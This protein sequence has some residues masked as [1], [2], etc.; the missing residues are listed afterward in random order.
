MYSSN[1]LNNWKYCFW[2][3]DSNFD[4]GWYIWARTVS[5]NNG[6]D[7]RRRTEKPC[8][9]WVIATIGQWFQGEIGFS[10]NFGLWVGWKWCSVTVL[11]AFQEWKLY[12]PKWGR[13]KSQTKRIKLSQLQPG[14]GVHIDIYP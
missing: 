11:V 1:I 4:D 13:I 2:L 7:Y 5:L 10:L 14:I 6:P 3:K 8:V 12:E 9:T